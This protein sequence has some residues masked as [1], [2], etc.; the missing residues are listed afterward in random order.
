MFK[1]FTKKSTTLILISTI[2]L[3]IESFV[4][5]CETD[6]IRTIMY[7]ATYQGKSEID[8]TPIIMLIGGDK[9]KN[10]LALYNLG[11]LNLS[12]LTFGVLIFG[13]I[14]GALGVWLASKSI[15]M[16]TAEMRERVYR[17][18]QKFSFEDIDKFSTSSLVT[19]LTTDIELTNT[20]LS[21]SSKFIAS[22]L[23]SIVFGIIKSSLDYSDWVLTYAFVIPII[24]VFIGLIVFFSM[25]SMSRGQKYIDSI[26]KQVRETILGIRVVKAYNLESKQK[27]KF[28]I[29]NESLAKSWYKGYSLIGLLMPVLQCVISGMMV[30]IYFITWNNYDNMQAA[31]QLIGFV[32][33][34]MQV[35]FG[36]IIIMASLAQ[37]SRSIPC[38]KRV[39]EITNFKPS[40]T[41]VENSNKKISK[42]I[43]EFK[44]VSHS[45]L[46]DDAHSVLKNINLKINDKERIGVIGGTGSGKSTLIN[47]I[48]RLFDATKGEVL[49]D[50]VNV[51]DFSFNEINS[52]VAIAMQS[53]TLF[54]GTI[55]SNIAL[56]LPDDIS[57]EEI[58]ARSKEVAV[59]AEAWE[60]I[61]KKENQLDSI[62]EQRG[63]NFS[64]GQKQR[65]SI[66]RTIAKKS[67]IVIF[68]DSTSALDTITERKVQ[69]NIRKYND[70]TTII[71]AQRISSVEELDRIIVMNNGEI[72][73]FDTHWNLLA[74]NDT[75]RSIAASQLGTEE[76]NEILSERGLRQI[77]K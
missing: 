58:V 53:A 72:V 76:L 61:S 46:N 73:G 12:L 38:V 26:N 56:G 77:E 11:D 24:V 39:N 1:Y 74:N 37:I 23:F 62:V 63:K 60:F 35:L 52:N 3:M 41:F 75:Y 2:F 47:L 5:I 33:I 65:I 54:S 8:G 14:C 31:G 45:F 9:A 4:S 36:F 27:S 28:E 19:R 57:D 66:A 64:G 42:G 69:E 18:I 25:P 34:L 10:I 6:F 32:G 7:R 59:A 49:I 15:A 17:Q 68:D 70:A 71:V 55:K 40:L 21:F 43:I 51:K 67:K 13:V 22:G 48:A 16:Y 44:N 20:S 30:V 50:G 29:P